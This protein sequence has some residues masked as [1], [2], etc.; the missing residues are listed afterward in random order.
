[1]PV[2]FTHTRTEKDQ[3]W[4][5]ALILIT[6]LWSAMYFCTLKMAFFFSL[7]SLS[8]IK[9]DIEP[10]TPLRRA[11]SMGW[12]VLRYSSLHFDLSLGGPFA[13]FILERTLMIMLTLWPFLSCSSIWTSGG[14]ILIQHGFSSLFWSIMLLI[15]G[16]IMTSNF[17]GH[18]NYNNNL[19]QKGLEIVVL[20]ECTE[21]ICLVCNIKPSSSASNVKAMSSAKN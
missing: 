20:V 15:S 8:L 18:N 19:Y 10:T 13:N 17:K 9:R 4:L 5:C 2:C 1:M 16:S 12:R 6:L 14:E 3:R 11:L 7:F 21:N